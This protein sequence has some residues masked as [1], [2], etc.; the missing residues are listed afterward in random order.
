M[1]VPQRRLFAA[2]ILSVLTLAGCGPSGGGASPTPPPPA[3]TTAG[4]SAQIRQECANLAAQGQALR[5][6]VD[7]LVAGQTSRDQVRA[8]AQ[9]FATELNT[10]AGTLG[11]MVGSSIDDAKASVQEMLAALNAQ[12][13]DVAGARAAA[14]DALDGL[15]GTGQ[16]CP[17][18]S[19]SA[20]PTS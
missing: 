8:A 9:S 11:S 4:T 6:Q 13:V 5:T 17:E 7:Q 16:V 19:R 14:A 20:T 3:T 2:V 1:V 15:H 12:P 10:A 18:F